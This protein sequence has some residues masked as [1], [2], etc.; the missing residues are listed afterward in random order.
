MKIV[1]IELNYHSECLNS[2]CH[3]FKGR[4]DQVEIYTLTSIYKDL[5]HNNYIKHFTWVLCDKKLSLFLKNNINTIN[6]NDVVLIGTL[7]K[8]IPEFAALKFN[9]PVILRVHGGNF[10]FNRKHN[11]SLPNTLSGIVD[12][13]HFLVK[14]ILIHR[15]LK[16]LNTLT[17]RMKNI[18]FTSEI[19]SNHFRGLLQNNHLNIVESIP[20]EVFEPLYNEPKNNN[21]YTIA[22]PGSVDVIRRDYKPVLDALNK[23]KLKINVPIEVY[24]LGKPIGYKGRQVVKTFKSLIHNKISIYTFDEEVQQSE[25]ERIM[26]KTN[27]ILSLI[28]PVNQHYFYLEQVGLTKI[29]GTVSDIIRYGKYGLVSDFYPIPETMKKI[30]TRYKSKHDLADRLLDAINRNSWL[31]AEEAA[32][33]FNDY[34][35]DAVYNKTMKVFDKILN[36]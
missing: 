2:F 4:H 21:V 31:S 13:I 11:F 20:L 9:V 18:S 29:S 3:A 16:L 17:K 28:K 19:V 10:Y 8:S 1:F 15:E 6:K 27:L 22:I 5:S 25:F 34:S 23:I 32:I 35:A 7:E 12:S 26:K 36:H 30:I 14:S 24:L 33:V